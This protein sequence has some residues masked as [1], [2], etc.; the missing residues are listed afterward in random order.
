MMLKNDLGQDKEK[1]DKNA[2]EAREALEFEEEL[3]RLD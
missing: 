2:D 1:N 3:V